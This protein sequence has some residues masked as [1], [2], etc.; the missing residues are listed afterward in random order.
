KNIYKIFWNAR[1]GLRR[2][3][4]VLY[5]TER[6]V[7]QLTSEGLKLI[8]IAPNID[9]EKHILAKMEFK[10]IIREVDVMD[11]RIFEEEPMNLLAEIRRRL[12]I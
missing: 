3:Q 8:E 2:G 7:F 9:I 10:P 6:A 1:E 11:K 5:I 4:K 12:R